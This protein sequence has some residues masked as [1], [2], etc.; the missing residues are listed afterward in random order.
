VS[1]ITCPKESRGRNTG[2]RE[3]GQ[4]IKHTEF[5]VAVAAVVKF[6]VAVAFYY[7]DC[8]FLMM[9]LLMCF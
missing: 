9:L 4:D 2:F 3:S 8:G 1:I 6:L 5:V 7:C